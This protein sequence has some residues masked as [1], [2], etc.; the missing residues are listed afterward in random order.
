MTTKE[1]ITGWF[2]EGVKDKQDNLI[3]ACDTYDHTDYPIYTKGLK[4]FKEQYK[5]H[6]GVNMQ[7]IM[8]VYDLTKKMEPQLKAHRAFNYPKGFK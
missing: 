6:D 1:D 8:E 4:E 5:S 7:E 2:K 3:V